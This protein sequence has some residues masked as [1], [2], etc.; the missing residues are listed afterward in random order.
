M[1]NNKA[2]SSLFFNKIRPELVQMA[3]DYPSVINNGYLHLE[4]TIELVHFFGLDLSNSIVDVGGADGNTAIIFSKAFDKAKI[5]VFEPIKSTYSILLENLK[6]NSNIIPVNRG[7][8]SV[9]GRLKIYLADR[10]TSSSLFQIEDQITDP[11]FA[12]NLLAK[13]MEEVE[14]STLDNELPFDQHVNV[15]KIDVQ[16]YEL[17]VLR[18]GIHTLKRT[19]IVLLEMQNHKLYKDAPEYYDLDIFLRENG[20]SL[21]NI[22]PSIRQ[23][24]KLY[25]WDSIYVNRRISSKYDT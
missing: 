18:G 20:F 5:Y 4:K 6:G 1:K 9:Q 16:G 17:E 11:F 24:K 25:E 15:I 19:D 3:E 23:S 13:G 10:A 22:I 12:R 8:G 2:V 21:Y 14:I 7:L